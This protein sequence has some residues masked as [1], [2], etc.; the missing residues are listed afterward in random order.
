MW[1][2]AGIVCLVIMVFGAVGVGI[3]FASYPIRYRTEV[4]RASERFDIP[5]ELVF[6]VIRAESK[7]KQNA[8]SNKGAVGLMQVMPS[9]ARFVAPK[10]NMNPDVID[11]CDPDTNIII[12]TFYLRYLFNRF[13]ET[14]TVLAAYNAGEGR[15]TEWLSLDEYSE[16]IGDSRIITSTPFPA[17]NA[18]IDKVMGGLK[19]YKF[20]I[21]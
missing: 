15:V 21:R 13:G 12:G 6:S 17:T 20:R 7:F 3:I 10:I 16:T 1:K 2:I 5:P 8:V 4:Q 11:L 19:V 18:Y 14:R 9:T